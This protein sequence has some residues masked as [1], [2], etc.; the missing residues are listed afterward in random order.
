MNKK[1][2]IIISL[3]GCVIAIGIFLYYRS[4]NPTKTLRS[5]LARVFDRPVDLIEL[6]FPPADGRYPGAILLTPTRGQTIVMKREFHPEDTPV[7]KSN[8]SIALDDK[9]EGD[10]FNKFLGGLNSGGGIEVQVDLNDLR[11][12]ETD[13]SSD[14]KKSLLADE[15][16]QRAEKNGL[17]PRTIIRAYEA[18]ISY[19][20]RK[21]SSL[22]GESWDSLENELV[23][24]G[25]NINNEG[26]VSMKVN[27]PTVIAYE[28][29]SINFI[30][31]N[32]G[33]GAPNN[34]TFKNYVP[35]DNHTNNEIS[36]SNFNL[37]KG[38]KNVSY[39]ALGNSTYKSN[40]F[41]NLRV[42]DNS[43]NLISSVLNTSGANPIVK[44]E[45]SDIIT[46]REF[47]TI[48]E[49]TCDTLKADKNNSLFIFYY[50]GHAISGD[51]GQLYLVMNDYKGDPSVDIGKDYLHG[52]SRELLEEPT[53]PVRGKNFDD[54]FDVV[55]ALGAEYPKEIQGLYPVSKIAQKLNETKR[56]YIILIDACYSHQEMSK[57]RSYLNLTQSGDYFGIK[58][59]G[60]PAE[61]KKYVD[62]INKFGNVLY[63]NS[64]NVI[65]LSSAPGSIA[66]ET[67]SPKAIFFKNE[68][69]APL[70]NKVYNE[71]ENEIANGKTISY[72][73]FF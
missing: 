38:D 65:M 68:F 36:I 61:L 1:R 63:L 40:H 46:Q 32:L 45:I 35:N 20:I 16:V 23:K 43:I 17:N 47:E 52:L 15:S 51:N 29:M 19:T 6:N 18:T 58:V 22:K 12:Y 10:I 57:L 66:E 24:L 31:T 73:G 2:I 27:E 70:S 72:G 50:V 25:G 26:T 49:N 69:V 42:V 60:G 59:N 13:I 44:K 33:V 5:E 4:I 11:M 64:N 48:L 8:I 7:S 41:G 37:E 67:L 21:K 71:F 62:A 14:F 54:L 39:I 34:V 28:T 56:R 3:I 30:T 55:N 53:S 9:M